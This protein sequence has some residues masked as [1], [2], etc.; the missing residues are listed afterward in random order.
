MYGKKE[1]QT[2]VRMNEYSS[3]NFSA[4]DIQRY[5]QGL[6]TPEQR[7]ALEKAA[8]DDPFLADALEGYNY[9]TTPAEDIIYLKDKLNQKTATGK[10]VPISKKE[11]T[12]SWLR[13]AA[14]FLVLAGAG[15]GVYQLSLNNKQDLS[16]NAPVQKQETV[17]QEK[18]ATSNIVADTSTGIANAGTTFSDG[19][20]ASKKPV[21]EKTGEKNETNISNSLPTTNS[22][23]AAASPQTVTEAT[24][25]ALRRRAR[26]IEV[27]DQMQAN[28]FTGKVID[29]NGNPLRNVSIVAQNNKDATLSDSDGN[30]SLRANDSVVTATASAVGYE[31]NRLFLNVPAQN[32]F[33][34]QQSENGL[35][36]VVVK[37]VGVQRKKDTS[38]E[39]E[40]VGGW[41]K[42]EEYLKTN[43][44]VPEFIST[45]KTSIVV[46]VFFDIDKN[47]RPQN[48]QAQN[49]LCTECNVE[50]IRILK[51]GPLWEVKKNKKGKVSI[52]F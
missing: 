23:A 48:I 50:A 9:T 47:G 10:V 8:L 46:P 3:N 27:N 4:E 44:R 52:S 30:F 6:M 13:I 49:T 21:A 33:V 39:P 11:H 25:D 51:E 22:D 16:L 32:T 45:A 42:F 17:K 26:G 12:T 34:L 31:Q 19:R 18:P 41:K 43:I 37:G 14:L 35:Q 36:E 29:A 40:P 1:S 20:A 24:P 15:W 2:G 38:N 7:N 5:H 28:V